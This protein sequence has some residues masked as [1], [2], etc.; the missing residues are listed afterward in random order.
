MEKVLTAN[1]PAAIGP[2]VQGVKTGSYLFISGQLPMA[3]TTGQFISEDIGLQTEQSMKNVQAILE[4]AGIG[5]QNIVKTTIFTTDIAYFEQI[6]Q[7][8]ASFFS[9]QGFPARSVIEVKGL[10]KGAKVE[11][12]VIATT[13]SI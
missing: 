2:Y 8:Y 12:E 9:D 3:P 10:P 1:A 6:N 5:L 13:E 4:Q 7:V 11:I